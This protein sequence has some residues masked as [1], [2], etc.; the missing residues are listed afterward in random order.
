[1]YMNMYPSAWYAPALNF[2]WKATCTVRQMLELPQSL[3]YLIL[4][5]GGGG[6]LGNEV[7]VRGKNHTSSVC[8]PRLTDSCC[9]CS[10]C[11]H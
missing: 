9:F 2:V 1:M 3:T 8:M 11:L 7:G 10:S 4:T 6:P 5:G